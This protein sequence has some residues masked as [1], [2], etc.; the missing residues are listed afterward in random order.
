[1]SGVNHSSPIFPCELIDIS[2]L[3]R[4]SDQR[5][6]RKQEGEQPIKSRSF[7]R[8]FAWSKRASLL[9]TDTDKALCCGTLVKIGSERPLSHRYKLSIYSWRSNWP[10]APPL[11]AL[12]TGYLSGHEDSTCGS[13]KARKPRPWN[14]WL[15]AGKGESVASAIGFA[16]VRPPEVSLRK[17]M[18]SRV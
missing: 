11:A 3:C 9:I 12:A 6:C 1:M 18:M 16:W 15:P 8:Y 5:G 14:N 4:G 2:A 13:V 17:R 7:L 10:V